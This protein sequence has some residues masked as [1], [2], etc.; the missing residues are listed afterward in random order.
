MVPEVV[1]RGASLFAPPL[2]KIARSIRRAVT[3]DSVV[4]EF[5]VRAL[6]DIRAR[7]L[8]LRLLRRIARDPG[9]KGLLIR[10]EAA[11]GG[12]AATQDLRGSLS[13]FTER[14]KGLYAVL[15]TPGNGATWLASA[16]DRVFMS[17]M[18]EMSL[19]GVG[20]ELTFFGAALERIGVR[21]DFEA[22]GAYKSFGESYTRS[23]ASTANQEAI[24]SL[25]HSLNE[26]L[27]EG[28]AEGRGMS[29][30]AVH[31]AMAQAPLSAPDALA[32]GLVDE[33]A[34]EDEVHAWLDEAIGDHKRV[35]F[36]K[37][38]KAEQIMQ[39]LDLATR[40]GKGI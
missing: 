8:Q 17:P 30:Q 26:Q 23:F 11:P 4:V 2:I 32:L 40:S 15:E 6:P 33:L 12:W 9:V 16:C 5:V 25:I 35:G 28:V 19:L 27:I 14:G 29:V 21:P 24:S 34:Y 10:I 18:G 13:E 1:R 39:Q 22:A 7:E 38:I 37:W 31:N 20:A 36:D 3:S